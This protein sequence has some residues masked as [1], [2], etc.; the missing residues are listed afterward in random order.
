MP[1]CA[2]LFEPM[3]LG[4]ELLKS[5]LNAKKNFTQVVLAYLQPFCCNSHLE[6]ALQLNI[7]KYSLNPLFRGRGSKSFKVIDINKIMFI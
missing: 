2:G 5:P 4:L 1:A 3:R 7:A 6:C